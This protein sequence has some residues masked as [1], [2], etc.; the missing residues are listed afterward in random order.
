MLQ[1]SVVQGLALPAPARVCA[2]L[3]AAGFRE[4]EA[5]AY[6]ARLA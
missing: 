1:K 6:G 4:R 5:A 3:V 2:F